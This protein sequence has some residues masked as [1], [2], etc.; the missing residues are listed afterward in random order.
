[1][2]SAF[3][4]FGIQASIDAAFHPKVIAAQSIGLR[5]LEALRS[6]T[7][8]LCYCLK[9]NIVKPICSSQEQSGEGFCE[10][11]LFKD[12]LRIVFAAF[13]IDRFE[14]VRIRHPEYTVK[15]RISAIAGMT[16]KR[17]FRPY[18]ISSRLNACLPE[19]V[20]KW[21]EKKFLSSMMN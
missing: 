18:T 2:R 19:K 7:T 17:N 14:K 16:I 12:V 8:R 6:L 11:V 10:R 20:E 1:M 4:L 13:E 21:K 5:L 15:Y 3:F 9:Y